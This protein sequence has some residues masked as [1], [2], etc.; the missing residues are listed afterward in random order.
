MT[1][2]ENRSQ[3]AHKDAGAHHAVQTAFGGLGKD[4]RPRRATTLSA[5]PKRVALEILCVRS[6]PELPC[7]TH[8]TWTL[9]WAAEAAWT[10]SR[11]EA[12][13]S[14]IKSRGMPPDEV[15]CDTGTIGALNPGER[16]S[17][18]CG[19]RVSE[20][21][22]CHR[23]TAACCETMTPPAVAHLHALRKQRLC[24]VEN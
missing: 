6:R 9:S 24:G 13:A 5:C 7:H 14:R 12:P 18:A 20:H 8:S 23:T 21:C 2:A 15:T 4:R 11:R 19:D 17:C 10:L 22:T 3:Q 16:A 1:D